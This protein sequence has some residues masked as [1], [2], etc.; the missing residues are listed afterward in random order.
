V[1]SDRVERADLIFV[2]AGHR[3]RKIFGALLF[4]EGWAPAVLMSTRNPPF[5]ARVLSAEVAGRVALDTHVWSQLR[6]AAKEPSPRKG[7]FF[8]GLNP[9]GWSVQRIPI[10]RLG[11]L[12][13]IRAFASWIARRHDTRTVL[14]VSSRLHLRRLRLCCRRLVPHDRSLRYV[15]VQMSDDALFARGGRREQESP[16]LV[17]LEWVKVLV[18]ALL[19]PFVN[20]A[21]TATADQKSRQP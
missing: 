15:A 14:V 9:S 7:L 3:S 4:A 18:Y 13:E 11:T 6:E 17:A 19:L 5:I 12:T 16:T 1:K 8:A 10:G 2:L 20:R 21:Q